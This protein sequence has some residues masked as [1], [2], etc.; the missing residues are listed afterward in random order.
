M[1]GADAAGIFIGIVILVIFVYG[2]SV[3]AWL[4]WFGK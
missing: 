4:R 3:V 1:T 2:I